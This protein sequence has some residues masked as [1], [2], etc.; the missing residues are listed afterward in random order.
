MVDGSN[1]IEAAGGPGGV[2]AGRVAVVTGGS[3][4]IGLGIAEG[5]ARAGAG[6]AIWSRDAERRERARELLES[7]GGE[8]LAVPCDVADPD[9]IEAA[10]AMTLQRFGRIDACF[11]NAGGGD[12]GTPFLEMTIADFRRIT[13][14]NLDAVF[15]TL[16][17]AAR[18]MV[19]RGE[20]GSLV[21]VS[22]LAGLQGM[23]RGQHY[24]AA[25]A[26][27]I[28]LTR[29]CAV[30]LGKH[31]IRANALVPGWIETSATEDA[32][33]RHSLQEKVLSRIPARRWG[34]PEDF[35]GLAVYLAGPQSE[36][37]SGD[38]L[39]VDGAYVDF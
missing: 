13:A 22:S 12:L 17:G 23:A 7:C 11:A 19:E 1:S 18:H 10:F 27:V 28:A 3:S 35:A 30:E 36:Y 21:G 39:V 25:K 9:A 4:G 38:V 16:Q 20:G 37:H 32:F 26:G 15:L 14:V 29:S 24:S 31:G 33:G 34:R 2:L 5:L 6:V 8:V